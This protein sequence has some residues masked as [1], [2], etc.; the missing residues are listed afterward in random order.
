MRRAPVFAA[1]V[2][3][4]VLVAAASAS[5]RV[6]VNPKYPITGQDAPGG[7]LS[8]PVI[9]AV[10]DCSSHV[11]VDSFMPKATVKVILNGTTIIG[12]ATPAFAFTAI[13]LTQQVH[14]DDKLT[15]TQTV[16]ARTSAPS[17]PVVVGKMP[18]PL[19]TPAVDTKI[20]ACGRVVP[21]HDLM[22][23]V[24]VKVNDVTAGNAAI[25]SGFT[26]NDWGS[27]WDPATTSALVA[28]HQVTATQT[29]CGT[30]S[31]G[32]SAPV[33]VLPEPVPV[34]PPVLQ[35]P[36]VGND[37][38]TLNGLYTG[39]LIQAFDHT[40][41]IGSGLATGSS[42]WMKVAPIAAAA[43]I[44][45]KQTLCHG[46]VPSNPVQPTNRLPAPVLLAP[47]CPHAPYATVRDTTIDATL[48][49]LKNGAD[50]GNAGAGPGDVPITIAPP[51][52]FATGD[53][54]QVLQYIGTVVSPRS[55]TVTVDCDSVTTY[56]YDN[57]RSGL[58]ASETGLT[59][60]PV[61]D[62]FGLRH[63]VA[64]DHQVDAQPLVMIGVPITA[65]KFAKTTHDV[66][67]VATENDTV[68]AIDAASGTVLLSKHLGAPI[69]SPLGC[70]NNGPNVGINGTPVIDR[71]A[72]VIY[73]MAYTSE[74][75]HP[76][77]RLHELDL[78]S[79]TDKVPARLVSGSHALTDHSTFTF[80][81]AYQRQRPALLEANG[82]VYAGFG[83]FCDWG[84]AQS[85]GWLLGWHAGSLAPLPAN[86]MNDT[87]ATSPDTF[88]LSSI[89][90]SGY[91][92]AADPA[93][94][95]F[96]V[97]GNSDTPKSGPTTYDGVNNIQE[98]VANVNAD[99]THVLSL[100][101]PANVGTLDQGDTDYGSGG[102]LLLPSQNGAVPRLAAAAGKDGRMFLL[103]RDSLGGFTSGGPDHVV[104]MQNVGGCWC[105]QSYYV[106]AA[107]VTHIVSSG[108]NTVQTWRLQTIPTT[109]L[110]HEASSAALPG[111]Q[112]PGFFTSVSMNGTKLSSAII[113]AV[114]RPNGG[115][116]NVTLY[117]FGLPT[118][119]APGV[120]PT[121]SSHVAGTWPNVSGN[122]NIVPVV[123]KGHVYVASN[124]RL[125]IFGL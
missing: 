88:F 6:Y 1:A 48:V 5:A 70:N 13:Q 69:P 121:L 44:T 124:K 49:L 17:S 118:A 94:S 19:P 31:G 58:N 102:A 79:L 90:M 37:A 51:A 80:N 92:V 35:Q 111:A 23:G 7:T 24:T 123:S 105:G 55:N 3:C 108:G 61:R 104:D 14:F 100:F 60:P 71:T 16:N 73:V 36:V 63:A 95:L 87:L 54:I 27:D 119:S 82:V 83:S 106:D 74:S 34:Q 53:K 72:G 10:D 30:S 22:P 42:N 77:Y 91:G 112:D 32:P 98:S 67:Y 8:P 68:Y 86:R 21:V 18:A 11:Y 96:F 62:N 125:A 25:G 64:L 4:V 57:A 9:S 20:Y 39:A 113:W 59:P 46:S 43:S 26:P 85:R 29:A 47:I 115:A 28:G 81:A 97:T 38:L 109:K 56:H 2:C 117:A 40:T 89:W 65:G 99:L 50:F 107:G 66:V 45:A 76:V 84:G 101:T 103:N 12:T 33:T 15:A 52:A 75:G 122:A 41:G 120:L 116:Q 93:G 110:I 114:S 78:G